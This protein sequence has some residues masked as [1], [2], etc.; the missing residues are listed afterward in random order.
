MNKTYDELLEE[1]AK[2]REENAKLREENARLREENT[3]LRNLVEKLEKRVDDLEARLGKNSKNSSRPPSSDQKSNLP[4]PNSGIDSKNRPYHQGA[5]RV[6]LPECSVTSREVRATDICP[7]CRSRM[8]RTG[9]VRK[10]QTIELPEIEPLVHQIEL[11]TCV[12]PKCRLV[13]SPDLKERELFLLGPRLEALVNLCLG[14]F[15]QSHRSV[16][17]FF[18]TLIPDLHLSQGIIS[19]VKCRAARMLDAAHKHITQSILDSEGA[20]HV[21]VTGWRHRGKNEHA[22]VLRSNNLVSFSFTQSQNREVIASLIQKRGVYLVSDR[23]LAAAHVDTR[24]RQYCLA[25]LLR[26]IQGLAEHPATTLEETARLGDLH[27]GIRSLFVDKH[28]M[29]RREIATST[30][31]QYGYTTWNDLRADVQAMTYEGS[32]KKV[33]RFCRRMLK[34]WGYFMSYLRTPDG[35][36]TNNPAEEALRSLV[37]A[38]K[39]CFGSRSEYGRQWRASLQSCIDTLRR[40]GH[41]VLSFLTAIIEAARNERPL[42]LPVLHRVAQ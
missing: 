16:R 5:S 35:P 26:N 11:H 32:S 37:I 19:K 9:E 31:R 25:H 41:S 17:E 24:T 6:L 14:R 40:H 33:G 8:E 39:L 10:W 7:R 42:P 18:A 23:G 21:D 34:D 29:D 12:C 27:D 22:I 20:L 2:L 1:N 30:W 15:R 36:M 13:H 4:P 3:L 28:R 38:R